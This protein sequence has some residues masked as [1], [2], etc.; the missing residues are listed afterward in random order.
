MPHDPRSVS[1]HSGRL[2]FELCKIL[3]DGVHGPTATP[4]N[5][6]DFTKGDPILMMGFTRL[7]SFSRD[8][9]TTH[10]CPRLRPPQP[11]QGI[12][13]NFDQMNGG[14]QQGQ[15]KGKGGKNDSK[16]TKGNKGTQKGSG[17]EKGSSKGKGSSGSASPV[18]DRCFRY[19][20]GQCRAGANCRYSHEGTP[21]PPAQATA[22]PRT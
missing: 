10:L 11:P 17:Q 19:L 15:G 20:A 3:R 6:F 16:G 8:M 2:S 21:T 18:D 13:R 4:E 5:I 1:C 22:V 14:Q 12:K 9:L 7:C